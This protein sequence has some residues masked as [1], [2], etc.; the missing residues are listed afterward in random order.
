MAR[1]GRMGEYYSSGDITVD[2]AG[3]QDVDPS[4]IDYGYKYAHDYVRGI[5]RDPKGWRMGQK[6]MD[7][8]ITLT[9][10]I[11]REF[12]K[13]APNRDIARIR[14]FPIIVVFTNEENEIIVDTIIAKFTGNRRSVTGDGELESEL[15]LFVISID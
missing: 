1:I 14:P 7:A 15:E 10:D 8:K 4:A 5:K 6:E 12:E 9:L 3:M 11:V 13:V 2:I